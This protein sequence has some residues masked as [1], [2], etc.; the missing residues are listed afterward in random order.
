MF[1]LASVKRANANKRNQSASG[2]WVCKFTADS[3]EQHL[4][5]PV[6]PPD[7]TRTILTWKCGNPKLFKHESVDKSMNRSVKWDLW[8]R[9]C[10]VYL[11][12]IPVPLYQPT[13]VCVQRQ[14][15]PIHIPTLVA[16]HLN[17]CTCFSFFNHFRLSTLICFNLHSSI[18]VTH[19]YIL[20]HSYTY[21]YDV[22]WSS[23]VV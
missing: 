5:D 2:G 3:A 6:N 19:I 10:L 12:P 20:R 13:S 15:T 21:Y 16:V 22:V 1:F 4:N 18:Y 9:L 23:T 8:L 11:A 17:P 7:T 14:C